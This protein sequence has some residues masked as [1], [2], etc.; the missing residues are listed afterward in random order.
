MPQDGGRQT[1]HPR[2]SASSLRP[3]RLALRLRQSTPL[4]AASMT[5]SSNWPSRYWGPHTTSRKCVIAFLRR[6]CTAYTLSRAHVLPD[7]SP[8]T[9]L[10]KRFSSSYAKCR[11]SSANGALAS[12]LQIE[13]SRGAGRDSVRQG[14]R[15]SL[16]PES[17]SPDV[18]GAQA[19]TEH[20]A[21]PLK[22][23]NL[24]RPP[25]GC[26]A[27]TALQPSLQ[28]ASTSKDDAPGS[29]LLAAR[30]TL[31]RAARS[32]GPLSRK[33]YHPVYGLRRPP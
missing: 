22:T 18:P 25:S 16:C 17:H 33:V 31:S 7:G 26:E 13:W 32:I 14:Q 27:P 30:V 23:V 15:V 6:S 21:P 12:Q 11:S 24:S 10:K 5:V 3:S 4:V 19:P 9:N 20:Q 1:S 8:R 29:V 2:S 28:A